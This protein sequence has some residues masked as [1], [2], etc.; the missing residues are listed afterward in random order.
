MNIGVRSR[1]EKIDRVGDTVL[2]R[3]LHRVEVIPESTAKRE[4]IPYHSVTQFLRARAAIFYIAQVVRLLRVI[5]HHAYFLLSNNIASEILVELDGRL[6]GH[7]HCARL[8][9]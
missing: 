5:L 7:A 1:I 4:C 6:Q 2:Y 9:V 8:V 3:E